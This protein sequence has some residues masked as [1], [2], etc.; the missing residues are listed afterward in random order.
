[1]NPLPTNPLYPSVPPRLFVKGE[2]SFKAF[3]VSDSSETT[4][5]REG[6][7]NYIGNLLAVVSGTPVAGE[8]DLGSIRIV[9]STFM[10][11]SD[12][13]QFQLR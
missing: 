9:Y 13:Q 4:G 8:E 10:G 5:L 7:G 6:R 2:Q 3:E 1:M 11:V 12:N